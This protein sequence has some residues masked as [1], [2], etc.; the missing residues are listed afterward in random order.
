MAR[1]FSFYRGNLDYWTYLSIVTV[2]PDKLSCFQRICHTDPESQP[3]RAPCA[4]LIYL[5]DDEALGGTSFYRWKDYESV[6]EAE[7][8]GRHSSDRAL[9]YLQA[10][11]PTF[12]EPP[13]YMTGSN[14]IAELLCTIQPRFNRLLFYSGDVPHS[15][16]ITA[17]ELLT[18]NVR[19]GRLTMNVYASV[20][21]KAA[22]RALSPL[23]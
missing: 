9:A 20:L 6:R 12:R 16:S 19:K 22:G 8:I 3:G 1:H 5:F 7:A 21:P 15:G 17:P 10:K 18:T 11:F 13:C 14:E 2:P 23:G 4:A